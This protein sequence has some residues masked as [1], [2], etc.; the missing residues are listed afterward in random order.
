MTDSIANDAQFWSHID[1]WGGFPALDIYN[2]YAF[3]HN[4]LSV[5]NVLYWDGHAQG[6]RHWRFT[7]V[8]I[9]TDLFI[10]GPN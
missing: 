4:G 7:G 9:W 2:A 1:G 3:R 8:P 10:N 5:C 6:R